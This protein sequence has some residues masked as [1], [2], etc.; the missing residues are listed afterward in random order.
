MGAQDWWDECS[1]TRGPM[2]IVE[3]ASHVMQLFARDERVLAQL[4]PTDYNGNTIPT[5]ALQMML[6]SAHDFDALDV[7]QQVGGPAQTPPGPFVYSMS[8][9]CSC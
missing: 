7:Q 4:M 1:G 2:D 8:Q 6:Q 5:H 3:V 9:S